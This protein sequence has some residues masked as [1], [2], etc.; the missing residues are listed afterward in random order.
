MACVVLAVKREFWLP[1]EWLEV[2]QSLMIPHM[3]QETSMTRL[4]QEMTD[5]IC[6]TFTQKLV[7]DSTEVEIQA[8]IGGSDAGSSNWAD[9]STL[10]LK[11]LPVGQCDQQNTVVR[12]IKARSI[13]FFHS[14]ELL[15]CTSGL[16][17]A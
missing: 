2:R 8:P 16:N 10:D 4:Q 12:E 11:G 15:G 3:R 14:S 17:P 5:S 6:C 9:L 13:T 1:R 7:S